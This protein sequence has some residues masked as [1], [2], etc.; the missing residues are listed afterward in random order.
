MTNF[1]RGIA[2]EA[3]ATLR[4]K[5]EAAYRRGDALAKRDK[6]IPSHG[7]PVAEEADRALS[8][9]VRPIIVFL[10]LRTSHPPACRDAAVR[11]IV[12]FLALR[13]SHP[14]ACRDAAVGRFVEFLALRTSHRPA[15][16]DAAVGPF[17]EFLALRAS[18]GRRHP[19][20]PN[21]FVFHRNEYLAGRTV[22]LRCRGGRNENR[23]NNHCDGH[24]ANAKT[25]GCFLSHDAPL[26]Q[27]SGA[28]H[29]K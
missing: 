20:Q 24:E 23:P 5:T 15:C 8:A 18:L 6:L 16:R 12:E 22:A 17:V 11:P 10:A 29:P 13:A 28:P 2:E 19:S 7:F 9:T 14:P 3:L 21:A 27:K 1:P 26:R 4:A 25:Q